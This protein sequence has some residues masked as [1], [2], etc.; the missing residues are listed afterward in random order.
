MHYAELGA[1]IAEEFGKAI[2]PVHRQL[3]MSPYP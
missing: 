1:S 2:G 3:G